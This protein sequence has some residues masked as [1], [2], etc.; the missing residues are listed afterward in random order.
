MR[1]LAFAAAGVLGA[2]LIGCA[3]GGKSGGKDKAK[4][5]PD[6]ARSPM[7]DR[8][9][10]KNKEVARQEEAGPADAEAKPAAQPAGK[11]QVE[12]VERKILYTGRVEATVE[13]FDRAERKLRE[14]VRELK[15]YVANS[16][17][18]GTTGGHRWGTWTVRIPSASFDDFVSAVIRLGE[19][20]KATRDSQ[21]VT[22]TYYDTRAE[23]K[24]LEASEEA[25][26]KLYDKK[27]V[28]EKISDLLEVRRELEKVRGEINVRKGQLQRWDK[29]AEYAT[30][31][32]RLDE[33]PR[34]LPEE[35]PGFGTRLSRTWDASIEALTAVGK[36]LTLAAAALVP[37]LFIVGLVG[38]P[39]WLVARRVSRR[40]PSAPPPPPPAGPNP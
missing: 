38:V 39:T 13:D 3:S 7:Q 22:D 34:Y 37:W 21:D 23:V 1:L 4:R 12:P 29:L 9:Q 15:G 28:G 19:L 35:S 14:Q 25:L 26:R 36:G 16:E 32:V 6:A 5:G 33:R 8:A 27:I 2:V 18:S 30:V 11:K 40:P 20:Q 24:N 10:D 31:N 17:V